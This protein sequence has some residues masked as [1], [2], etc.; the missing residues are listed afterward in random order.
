MSESH[1]QT[2]LIPAAEDQAKARPHACV[3]PSL[4]AIAARYRLGQAGARK[5]LWGKLPHGRMGPT[6]HS[7]AKGWEGLSTGERERA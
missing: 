7:L 3:N 4:A 2:G 1:G 6:P 5:E